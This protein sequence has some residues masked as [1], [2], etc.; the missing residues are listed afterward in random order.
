MCV[1]MTPCT[2]MCGGYVCGCD[3]SFRHPDCHNYDLWSRQGRSSVHIQ[4]KEYLHH[5]VHHVHDVF[6]A[7]TVSTSLLRVVQ[8]WCRIEY[9]VYR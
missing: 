9:Q 5:P 8:H 1:C 6:V 2:A 7:L 3:A 4:H